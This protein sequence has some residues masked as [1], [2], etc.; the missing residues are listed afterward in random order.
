MGANPLFVHLLKGSRGPSL[1]QT[2]ILTFGL[3]LVSLILA[4]YLMV[5]TPQVLAQEEQLSD[6][7]IVGAGIYSLEYDWTTWQGETGELSWFVLLGLMGVLAVGVWFSAVR[8]TGRV[9][10]NR[11]YQ[12]LGQAHLSAGTVTWGL[13]LTAL[14]RWRIPLALMV[15][16]TPLLAVGPYQE[17]QRM[18]AYGCYVFVSLE[19]WEQMNTSDFLSV[20]D[21]QACAD[22][23]DHRIRYE[24]LRKSLMSVGGATGMWG[25][26]LLLAALAVMLTLWWRRV[27]P[28]YLLFF[29]PLLLIVIPL[30]FAGPDIGWWCT[31]SCSKVVVWPPVNE[32]VWIIGIWIIAPYVL[33]LAFQWFAQRWV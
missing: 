31:L 12:S 27:V 18:A 28:V 26:I 5:R 8:L 9:V 14:Y 20:T 10:R 13:I 4:A 7:G 32:L 17:A 21:K 6:I 33:A 3:G 19:E 11:Y 23:S 15:G 1:H 25:G 24:S 22:P 2:L 16:L 30:T 29:I